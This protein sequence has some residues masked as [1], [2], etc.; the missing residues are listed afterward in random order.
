M[1]TLLEVRPKE[2]VFCWEV[3][4]GFE[5]EDLRVAGGILVCG[6]GGER[7]IEVTYC[8]SGRRDDLLWVW[9]ND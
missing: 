4:R 7:L 6:S 1:V 8:R 9:A 5:A 3:G 2:R